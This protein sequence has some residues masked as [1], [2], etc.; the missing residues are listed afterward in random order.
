MVAAEEHVGHGAVP[1]ARGLRVRGVLEKPVLVALLD[2]ALGVADDP[3]MRRP[4]ASIIAI[5]A[6]SPPL[7]T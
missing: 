2:E 4:M 3:G 6:T 5:V 1:P 7:S